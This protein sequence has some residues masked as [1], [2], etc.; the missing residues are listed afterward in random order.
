[1]RFVREVLKAEPAPY[2]EDILRHL[3]TDKRVS[4]RG[5][6]GIGKTALTAWV[7]W[8]GVTVFE[9]D[10]KIV[11]TAS[12][13]RQ[14][15]HFTWPEIRKWGM[16]AD[17]SKFGL[18]LRDGKELLERQ[19]KLPGKEAFAVA[20]DTPSAIEGAHA[21]HLIYVFD[22]AKA[23]PNG[24][25]D[26]AE[27]AFATGN[28]Y[29]VAPSTPGEPSG[30]F[31]DIHSRKPGTLDWWARH[32][33]LQEAVDAGRVSAE[34]AEQR[35]EQW[36]EQSAVYQNRVLGEFAD[37]GEDSVIPLAWIEA[38][39][40][41]WRECDGKGDGKLTYGCDPARYGTDQTAIARLVGRV[42]E[43]I[44]RYGGLATT[45]TTGKVIQAVAQDKSVPV[46][47]DTIGVGAGV[48]DQ[49]H[50]QK[51]AAVSVN[52]SEHTDML[53]KTRSFGFVNLR[54]GLWW[55]LRE[56]LDPASPDALALPPDDLLTG[57]LTAPLYSTTSGGKIA[58]ES[59][60]DMRKR[61]GRSPDSADALA[62]ALYVA[63]RRK[64]FILA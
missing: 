1:M 5:P 43:K 56:A 9:E 60:D 17:W 25:W 27:G 40:L 61:L 22:E 39:N 53:D 4:F 19:I 46:G 26:A 52:V 37:S 59:K 51:Y 35:K 20:S 31:Y 30:R 2:Q 7:V 28:C 6:H 36:G 58:V 49:L 62:L 42:L 10:T 14:L 8:W 33:T 29:A 32:V 11:T 23:I 55:M 54:S 18:V 38:S 13:W 3:V 48:Y 12:Q 41:R 50:E 21:S 44:D 57:D 16:K 34:W 15:I 64:G 63:Q 45:Q 24:I 47:V